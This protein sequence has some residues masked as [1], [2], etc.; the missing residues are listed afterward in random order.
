VHKKTKKVAKIDDANSSSD[1]EWDFDEVE[2]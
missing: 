2:K 1:D